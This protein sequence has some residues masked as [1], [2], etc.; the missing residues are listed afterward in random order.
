MNT[1]RSLSD[2][3]LWRSAF[4]CVY[5]CSLD[6]ELAED[7]GNQMSWFPSPSLGV[8]WSWDSASLRAISR[9]SGP[10]SWEDS[11]NSR[12]CSTRRRVPGELVL[13]RRRRAASNGPR[14]RMRTFL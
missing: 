10:S 13:K 3:D 1:D 8:G 11:G 5:L 2:F 6:E 9:A 7:V 12:S 4:I 14:R